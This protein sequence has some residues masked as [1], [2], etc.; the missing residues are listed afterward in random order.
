MSYNTAFYYGCLALFGNDIYPSRQYETF[1][2]AVVNFY[3]SVIIGLLIGEFSSLLNK[4][5]ARDN[6][7]ID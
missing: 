1:I 3:G 7:E 4:M 2:G 5:N 6:E